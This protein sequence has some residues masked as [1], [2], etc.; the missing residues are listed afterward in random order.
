M[1]FFD[2]MNDDL[3]GLGWN[4]ETHKDLGDLSD[5]GFRFFRPESLPDIDMDNR[6]CIPPG[7]DDLHNQLVVGRGL[8]CAT[9]P[10]MLELRDPFAKEF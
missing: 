8:R 2:F 1:R 5:D 7:T 6:H 4:T 3:D 10:S 9:Q